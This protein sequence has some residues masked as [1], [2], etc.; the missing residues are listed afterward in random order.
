M[1]FYF[2]CQRSS[3][4]RLSSTLYSFPVRCLGQD[5][6]FDLSVPDHCL[7]IYFEINKTNV[8]SHCE[9]SWYTHTILQG[10]CEY[11]FTPASPLCINMYY[12][13]WAANKKG[14]IRL[15]ECAGWSAPLLFTYGI[16]RFSHVLFNLPHKITCKSGISQCWNDYHIHPF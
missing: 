13:I 3:A 14:A 4:L 10:K 8:F 12:T 15:H 6:E 2:N 1:W 7:F 9:L 16:N 5:V 11:Y